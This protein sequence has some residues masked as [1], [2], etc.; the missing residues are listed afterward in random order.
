MSWAIGN[1]PDPVVVTAMRK[2]NDE[3]NS[4]FRL[5][6]RVFTFAKV[7]GGKKVVIDGPFAEGKEV[8]ACSGSGPQKALWA[9]SSLAVMICGPFECRVVTEYEPVNFHLAESYAFHDILKTSSDVA[10]SL[11]SR[12]RLVQN[13]T[14]DSETYR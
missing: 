4:P 7:I 13:S 1:K 9:T 3:R 14:I 2:Y 11:L 12:M 10:R 6:P 8:I 5:G